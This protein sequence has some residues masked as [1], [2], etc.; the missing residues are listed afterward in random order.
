[1]SGA[2]LA[3]RVREAGEQLGISER[4]AWRLVASGELAVIRAGRATL[5]PASA[6]EAWI[7]R[8]LSEETAGGLGSYTAASAGVG[9]G[10]HASTR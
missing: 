8:K 9:N 3:Y 4:A 10:N 6:L 5:V 2:R 7:T 1:M